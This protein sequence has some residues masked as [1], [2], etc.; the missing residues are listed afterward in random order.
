MVLKMKK[1]IIILVVGLLLIGANIFAQG[2]SIDNAG[3]ITAGAANESGSLE[4]NGQAGS[5]GIVGTTSGFGGAG[6]H[7]DNGT[8][9]WGELGVIVDAESSYGVWGYNTTGL[10]GFFEGDTQVNGNLTVTGTINGGGVISVTGGT[11]ITEDTTTG[12]ITLDIAFAGSSGSYGTADT[13]ARSDHNHDA[14]YYTEDEVDALVSSLQ[15]QINAL[16]TLLDKFSISEDGNE[17]YITGANL[18]VRNSSGST[19]GAV[20]G[21]GNIIIGYDETRGGGDSKGGSHNLV[22]GIRNNYSSFGGIVLGHFNSISADHASVTG[23]EANTASALFTTV[24]GGFGN[25]ASHVGSTVIGGEG[26][27]TTGLT[28]IKPDYVVEP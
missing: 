18:H 10:A 28:D 8:T 24:T 15:S 12:D 20:D 22:L 13:S 26:N 5:D 4:V 25:T 2:V 1:K 11:G 16:N 6:V 27:F 19:D 23:G 3:N 7:G 14:R 17:V 9:V 21:L